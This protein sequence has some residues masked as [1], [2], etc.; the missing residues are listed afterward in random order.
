MMIEPN[1]WQMMNW[2]WLLGCGR[3]SLLILFWQRLSMSI[4]FELIG[5]LAFASEIEVLML[6]E[7][8]ALT[9]VFTVLIVF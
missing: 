8:K 1:G 5:L 2:F 9:G 4:P 3:R 6:L 7:S